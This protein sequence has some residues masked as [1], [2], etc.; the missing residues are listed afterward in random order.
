MRKTMYY[1]AIIVLLALS[2][3]LF[4]CVPTKNEES[5]FER[6][7]MEESSNEASKQ[8][9]LSDESMNSESEETT[10]HNEESKAN[11]KMKK[12][13]KSVIL[14]GID[15]GGAFYKTAYTPN[16]DR[17]FA[18][19]ATTYECLTANPTISAQCWGTM[20]TGVSPLKHKFT[21]DYIAANENKISDTYPTVFRLIKEAYSDAKLAAFCN[22]N[23]IYNGIIEHD[24]GVINKTG[25]DVQVKDYILDYLKTDIPTFMFVQFDSVDAAG[26]SSGYGSVAHLCALEQIDA[27]V[28]E[29]YELL[30]SKGYLK[31]TLFLVTSDHGGFGNS[32]G[33]LTNDEKYVFF[34]AKGESI[35][36][37]DNIVMQVSDI[38]SIITYALDCKT[39]ESWESYIPQELFTDNMTPKKRIEYRSPVSENKSTPLINSEEYIGEFIDESKI[40]CMYTFDTDLKPYIGNIQATEKG[41]LYYTNGF[42]G[43][44]CHVSGEGYIQLNGQIF[45]KDSFSIACWVKMP[46]IADIDPC[47]YSNKNWASG[48]NSG[49]VLSARKNDI[50]FN[51]GY[52][53]SIRHDFTV[54]YPIDYEDNWFHTLLTVDRNSSKVKLYI[55]FILVADEQ[56]ASDF[57][58]VSFDTNMPFTIGQDGTGAF[59]HSLRSE[60]DDLIIFTE[61]LNNE[62][63]KA[64]SEYY[65]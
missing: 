11:D 7:S 53:G 60:I 46:E 64:L 17:I 31:D 28:G 42:N 51:L 45:A 49:F 56:L 1:S 61:A 54:S 36:N 8:D 9:N 6:T 37:N 58:S 25:D 35:N 22:W 10:N 39:S 48:S 3:I 62:E 16:I 33:G 27:Y 40:K 55:N 57:D 43:K 38:P 24:L 50:K 44:S 34:G 13:Y 23:P 19:G 59:P 4:S 14:L 21:N 18:E 15:G 63:I 5:S 41:K 20:L 65:K 47:I 2:T 52:N 12:K 29:I 32:H 30:E 26:H